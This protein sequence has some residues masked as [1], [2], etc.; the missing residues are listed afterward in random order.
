MLRTRM[1][2]DAL[3]ETLQIKTEQV[4]SKHRQEDAEAIR[5][6]YKTEK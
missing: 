3:L 4:K 5:N 1:E 2:N 6:E